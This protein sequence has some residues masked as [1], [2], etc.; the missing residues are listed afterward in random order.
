MMRASFLSGQLL[1]AAVSV[2]PAVWAQQVSLQAGD[3]A[4]QIVGNNNTVTVGADVATIRS[5]ALKAA[6]TVSANQRAAFQAQIDAVI[7][8]VTDEKEQRAKLVQLVT[9]QMQS[10]EQLKEAL[11]EA[12]DQLVKAKAALDALPRTAERQSADAAVARGDVEP[13]HELVRRSEVP[14]GLTLAGRLPLR[15]PDDPNLD[16][17]V[18]GA[19]RLRMALSQPGSARLRF[20]PTLGTELGYAYRVRKRV[21][22]AYPNLGVV[23]TESVAEH[24]MGVSVMLGARIDYGAIA[25][26]ADFGPGARFV[27]ES[28]LGVQS[29]FSMQA[30]VELGFRLFPFVADGCFTKSFGPQS[31][32][33]LVGAGVSGIVGHP[34]HVEDYRFDLAGEPGV[35]ARDLDKGEAEGRIGVEWIL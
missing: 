26:A 35:V 8:S 23:S 7:A 6:G 1:T 30:G 17:F 34:F 27:G 11:A 33:L 15:K 20:W 25:A 2:S 18:G 24:L 9:A 14:L 16:R 31:W 29:R 21:T 4:I 19:T 32:W 22:N 3:H 13:A 28:N 10:D 12:L 5:I